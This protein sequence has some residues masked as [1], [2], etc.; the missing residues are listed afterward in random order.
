M[1]SSPPPGT[2]GDL[3]AGYRMAELD[4]GEKKSEITNVASWGFATAG[5][6]AE[7]HLRPYPLQAGRV[8]GV[9]SEEPGGSAGPA[10]AAMH[11]SYA[12]GDFGVPGGTLPTAGLTWVT[13]HPQHRRRG[14][15]RAMVRTHLRRTA[16]RH[17]PLSALW[18]SEPGI[19]GQF[20]YGRAS[21]YAAMRLRR[22]P[23][24]RPVPGQE[25]FTVRVEHADLE[26]H[27]DLVARVHG[28][29]QR[30]GWARRNT[31]E[32]AAGMFMDLPSER[33]GGE[34]LKIATV[35]DETGE[36]RAYAL[37][38]RRMRWA[39]SGAADGTVGVREAIAHDGPAARALWAFICDLDLMSSVETPMLAVD[40]PL[41][42]L[43]VDT[44]E[45]SLRVVDNMWLRVVDVPV[46]LAGRTYASAAELVLEVHDALLPANE[47]RW[48]LRAA[49]NAGGS[50]V[51]PT[52]D[53]ADLTLDVADLGSAYLGGVSLGALGAAGLVRE[54][55]PG[56]LAAA[57]AA[58]GWPL[59]PVCTWIF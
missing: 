41:L 32:L 19:Y 45:V 10:L 11:A 37:F 27:G 49:T 5:D 54:S 25:G 31:P 28:S 20:G 30:P 59:A 13:V 7:D 53:P 16:E 12:F 42:T 26:R 55:T 38:S 1:T 29:S 39:D 52:A 51:E 18:A 57:S 50:T 17:E 56:A 43:L 23:S 47:G 33:N 6:P 24:L 36:A 40:D 35:Q 15:G 48:R 8:V 22:Q 9:W 46:A 4:P 34:P 21:S 3:P 2:H 14:L 44:R 58:F